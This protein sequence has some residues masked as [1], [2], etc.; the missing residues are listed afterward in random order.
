MLC[1]K[2]L[3][4]TMVELREVID[5]SKKTLSYSYANIA[6]WIEEKEG[7]TIYEKIVLSAFTF[8]DLIIRLRDEKQIIHSFAHIFDTLNTM[9]KNTIELKEIDVLEILYGLIDQKDNIK[10]NC[11]LGI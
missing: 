11:K 6:I 1:E 3:I 5:K 8:Y 10:F 4:K 2:N 7:L 9:V